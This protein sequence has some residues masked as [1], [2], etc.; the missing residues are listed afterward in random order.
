MEEELAM[1]KRICFI[2]LLLFII[3]LNGYIKKEV[4]NM[5]S[6]S[7]VLFGRTSYHFN[8]LNDGM[9]EVTTGKRNFG[10]NLDYYDCQFYPEDVKRKTKKL[11]KSERQLIDEL[12]TKVK[13][14]CTGDDPALDS[15][16][17]GDGSVNIYAKIDGVKYSSL[18]YD[19]GPR[20]KSRFNAELRMLTRKLVEISPI[21][22]REEFL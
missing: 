4:V 6:A 12:I 10:T 21:K 7:V 14:S 20:S 1:N 3:V 15:D 18:Y 17:Q 9:L 2:I 13:T 16:L 22:I 11:T 8:V 5:Q 19:Y